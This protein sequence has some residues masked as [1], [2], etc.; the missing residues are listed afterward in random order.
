MCC[1][2][3]LQ[4]LCEIYEEAAATGGPLNDF[5]LFSAVYYGILGYTHS[6]GHLAGCKDLVL[7]NCSV[8]ARFMQRTL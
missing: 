8:C 6:Y 3:K 2:F 5:A 4:Q 7:P 1:R